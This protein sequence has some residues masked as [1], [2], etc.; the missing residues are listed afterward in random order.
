MNNVP[1]SIARAT[2][3]IINLE[4]CC[5][6]FIG[7]VESA[8][9]L[10]GDEWGPKFQPDSN[11]LPDAMRALAVSLTAIESVCLAAANAMATAGLPTADGR[12]RRDHQDDDLQPMP[13]E[14]PAQEATGE[15]ASAQKTTIPTIPTVRCVP[16]TEDGIAVAQF[17]ME[18]GQWFTRDAEFE[19]DEEEPSEGT[20]ETTPINGVHSPG[21]MQV[22]HLPATSTTPPVPEK[23]VESRGRERRSK[24]KKKGQKAR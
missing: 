12:R 24:G 23:P 6:Q 9:G 5:W 18:S 13:Q 7:E 20:H 15:E 8:F 11:T 10:H 17:D 22:N 2:E 4:D 14:S 1:E 3:S 16:P 19:E 21:G